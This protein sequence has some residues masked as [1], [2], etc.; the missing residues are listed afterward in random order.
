MRYHIDNFKNAR[1]YFNFSLYPWGVKWT[2][3]PVGHPV[4]IT[5]GFAPITAKKNPYF[6]VIKCTVVPPRKLLHPVL[7]YPSKGKLL[8]PLCRTCAETR[9]AGFCDHSDAERALTHAWISTEL[10]KALQMGY[11]VNSFDHCLL[12]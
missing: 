7:P 6:G 1:K 8:F 3:Y 11:E 5:E 4:V 12:F 9:R 10:D 2:K